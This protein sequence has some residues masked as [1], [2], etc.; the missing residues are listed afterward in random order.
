MHLA[1]QHKPASSGP[2]LRTAEGGYAMAVLLVAMSLMAVMMTV[3]MPVWKQMSQREKEA[4]LV[5]R[6]QQYARAIELMQR[7]M[8]GALPPN[9]DILVTQKFL[10]KKYKD[11]I[12]G[13][14]FDTVTPLQT[15]PA[16]APGARAGRARE[17]RRGS[18]RTQVVRTHQPLRPLRRPPGGRGASGRCRPAAPRP[19]SSASS[20][21]ART[22][23][24]VFTTAAVI[25]TSGSFRRSSARRRLAARPARGHRDA[26]AGPASQHR[27]GRPRRPRAAARRRTRRSRDASARWTRSRLP[28]PTRTSVKSVS[29]SGSSLR[30][31]T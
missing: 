6:G 31:S 24:F 11:P 14:D 15:A 1:G 20:A 13:Q 28:A 16:A 21:R 17:P 9:L 19:A 7:K 27:A 26:G 10:R 25:T 4:E 2:V 12:T 18:C 3:A 29:T 8:P 22:R 23:R 30:H 5:F